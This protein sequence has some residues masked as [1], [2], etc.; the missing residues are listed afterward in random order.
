[1]FVL[2]GAPSLFLIGYGL[3]FAVNAA[4]LALACRKWW[5]ELRALDARGDH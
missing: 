4:L 5:R 1:M 2:L 3:M